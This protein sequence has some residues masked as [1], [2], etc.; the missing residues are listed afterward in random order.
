[1]ISKMLCK[2]KQKYGLKRIHYYILIINNNMQISTSKTELVTHISQTTGIITDISEI[3]SSYVCVPF[4][5]VVKTLKD[6][7][8]KYIRRYDTNQSPYWFRYLLPE[9]I[10]YLNN[11]CNEENTFRLFDEI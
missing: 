5:N 7:E 9:G 3:V 4:D 2:N 6:V 11:L 1:M 10:D 8:R